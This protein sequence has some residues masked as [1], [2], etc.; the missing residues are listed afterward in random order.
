MRKTLWI[1]GLTLALSAGIFGTAF[2]AD[3]DPPVGPGMSWGRHGDGEGPLHDLMIEAAAEMIGLE[4]ADLEARLEGGEMLYQIALDQ[5]MTPEQF[6]LEWA[7]ARQTV[8]QAA[9][10]EGLI[11]RQQLCRML[12]RRALLHSGACDG[13]GRF[14][15]GLSQ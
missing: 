15:G 4:P 2:A 12:G 3:E 1:A 6:R 11:V 7:E 8:F 10:D 13:L 9:L 14:Q 5:G